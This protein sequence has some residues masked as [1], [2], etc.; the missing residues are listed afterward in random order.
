MP[1][2][3]IPLTLVAMPFATPG[4]TT[5]TVGLVAGIQK[6]ARTDTNTPAPDS[7]APAPTH[8]RIVAAALDPKGR[9]IASRE[10]TLTA[11]LTEGAT[12]EWLSR[13]ELA[14]GP[15]QIRVGINDESGH[16]GS[17]F[18]YVDVP[19]FSKDR[20]TLSGVSITVSPAALG[21]PADRLD[22]LTPGTPTGLRTFARTDTATAALR[23]HQADSPADVTLLTRIVDTTGRVVFEET[24]PVVFRVEDSA[25]R[26][27]DYQVA[28]PLARLAPGEYLLAIQASAKD[29]ERRRNVR[30]SVR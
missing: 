5:G 18:A 2:A 19:E 11:T 12:F 10:E 25:A 9:M 26:V 1:R 22:D 20:L 23:L 17:V 29:R 30:F 14:P 15:Y 13:L 6:P 7:R 21:V 8:L 16:S 27:A 4:R 3:G 28:L 24:Q